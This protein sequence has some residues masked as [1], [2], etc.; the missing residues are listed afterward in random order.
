MTDLTPEREQE[1]RDLL[2]RGGDSH[3][4]TNAEARL[5]LTDLLAALDAER[6]R[7]DKL[8]VDLATL[9][10]NWEAA[11]ERI[12]DLYAVA[13]AA[14]KAADRLGELTR[15]PWNDLTPLVADVRD[16]LRAALAV[17]EEPQ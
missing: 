5:A 3:L 12:T 9:N 17:L 14:Q 1:I 7:A 10:A 13:E 15:P 6:A 11:D 8:E 16:D 4:P 2:A